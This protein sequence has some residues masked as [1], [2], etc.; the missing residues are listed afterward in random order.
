MFFR[1]HKDIG[2]LCDIRNIFYNYAEKLKG[3]RDAKKIINNIY[4]STLQVALVEE[5]YKQKIVEGFIACSVEI[6][7]RYFDSKGIT[8]TRTR[9]ELLDKML[10]GE[11]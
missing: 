7:G 11:K 2:Y 10:Q 4:Y 1:A 5:G 9:K 8:D 3:N 6:A